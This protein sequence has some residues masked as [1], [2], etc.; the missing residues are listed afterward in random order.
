[1]FPIGDD[2]SARRTFPVVTY[3]LIALNVLFFFV[4]LSGGDP[5]IEKWAFVPARFLADP[6]RWSPDALHGHVHARRV[7]A[8]GRQ[9]ALLVDLRRQRGRPLRTHQVHQSSTC[10]VGIA[11]TFAQLAFSA[12][13]NVPNLGASGAIAGVL[14]AY[15][16]AVPAG[17]S[18]CIIGRSCDADARADRH[19]AVDRAAVF[20]RHRFDI[21][22]SGHGRRG[23]HGAH[24]R[25]YR[26]ACVDIRSQ[27]KVNAAAHGLDHCTTRNR[28]CVTPHMSNTHKEQVQHGLPSTSATI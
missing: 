19:W 13:S 20:Q 7:A 2:N 25:I 12:G 11:A 17:E 16:R 21:Q 14:G 26:R 1:M 27:K 4:E 10:S 22:H 28:S 18:Q 6:R 24:R 15:L 9:H 5:F 23:L 3:V 8:P